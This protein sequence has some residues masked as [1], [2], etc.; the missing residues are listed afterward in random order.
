MPVRNMLSLTDIDS[1]TLAQ[2]ASR[3]VEFSQEPN[4]APDCLNG[5]T[6][7]TLFRTTSTRTR[8]SFTVAA[9][10]LG[11]D[12]IAYGPSDLQLATGETLEDTGRVLSSYVDALVIRTNAAQAEMEALAGAGTLS[13][14]N[15]MSAEE[16][17]TQGIADVSTLLAVFG[18]LEDIHLLYLGE[19]N[20][21]VSAL[22]YAF[23]M[24]RRSRLTIMTPEGYGLDAEYL[25]AARQIA[26][27]GG[28][29]IEQYHDLDKLPT[30]VDSV[31]TTRWQTMGVA[32]PDPDWREKFLPYSVTSELMA[33][34]SKDE[35]TVFMHD[36]PA[37]R[38]DD[39]TS[40]VLDGPQSVAWRQAGFKMWSAMA[41]LEWCL[42]TS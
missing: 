42:A 37:V 41:V 4:G 6:V 35:G 11:A 17:P 20:N 30:G 7:A 18:R 28:S 8:T 21:T 9:Q 12:T 24:L 25:D 15:A 29:E 26:G 32:K 39:V 34:V 5:K 3:A 2:L 10:K 19:G 1:D 23:G 16:H 13:V 40:E 36:L 33:R 27:E 22:A 31:Y 38:G 14:I